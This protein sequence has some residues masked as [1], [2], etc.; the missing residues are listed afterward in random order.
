MQAFRI[1]TAL[2]TLT[3]MKVFYVPIGVSGPSFSLTTISDW[4]S[5]RNRGGLFAAAVCSATSSQSNPTGF[6]RTLAGFRCAGAASRILDHLTHL[7]LFSWGTMSI[8][9][10]FSSHGFTVG[11]PALARALP[12][13]V[14]SPH[15]ADFL[16]D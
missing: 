14:S 11:R 8:F 7:A 2:T 10:A 5:I 16:S 9:L 1:Q 15:A 13:K 12:V 4:P 6:N 3:Y